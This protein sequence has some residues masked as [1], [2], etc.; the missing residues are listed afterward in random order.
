MTNLPGRIRNTNL[1]KSHALLPLFEAVVN[2]IHA[3]EDAQLPLREGEIRIE[4]LREDCKHLSLDAELPEREITGFRIVDN[5]V[6]F[7]D[8]NMSSFN[9]LDSEY[10]QVRG[11]KGIGRLLWLKAFRCVSVESVFENSDARY[12]RSFIFD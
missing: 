3:I 1:P 5:G 6:G 4:V 11:G 8:T 10:K 9:T 12:L 2:S 7:T